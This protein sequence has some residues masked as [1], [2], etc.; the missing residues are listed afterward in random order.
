MCK[1]QIDL[2]IALPS[3]SP[4]V[5][6]TQVIMV[7]NFDR[8]STGGMASSKVKKCIFCISAS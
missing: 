4:V 1:R 5:P 8:A 6:L 3:K 2:K 7:P